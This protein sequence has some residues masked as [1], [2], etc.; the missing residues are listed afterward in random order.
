MN[1]HLLNKYQWKNL[2]IKNVKHEIVIWKLTQSES[3]SELSSD[4]V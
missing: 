3:E 2:K 4:C 1:Q